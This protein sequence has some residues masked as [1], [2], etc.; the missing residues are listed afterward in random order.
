MKRRGLAAQWML[1]RRGIPSVLYY[2]TAAESGKGLAAHV[3]V[4]DGESAVIGGKFAARFT[5]LAA[6]PPPTS[7]MDGRRP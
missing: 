6:F 7:S 4:K 3:W 5:V 2:G 1:R